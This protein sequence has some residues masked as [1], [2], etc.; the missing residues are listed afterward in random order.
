[1]SSPEPS[2]AEINRANA[3]NSTGPRTPEGKAA[4]RANSLTHG[5][6]SRKLVL[7]P[8]ENPAEFEQ[9]RT[10]MFRNLA[11]AGPEETALAETI[12]AQHWRLQRVPVLE[13]AILTAAPSD[14]A[15]LARLS[16]HEQRLTRLLNQNRAT[17]A[18][19]QEA[20]RAAEHE[21][22]AQ[23]ASLRKLHADHNR[24]FNPA[25]F[26]FVFSIEEID[27]YRN[28]CTEIGAAQIYAKNAAQAFLHPEFRPKEVI[29]PAAS[30]KSAA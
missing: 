23:A 21:Q 18:A 19:L 8:S 20:R 7:L 29:V 13:A 2:R 30:F 6:T 22:M 11:P 10:A 16:L 15:A 28:R 9:F 26:G 25:E 1:M 17:F 27:R 24:P 4:S 5:L 12:V 14:A 3:Q